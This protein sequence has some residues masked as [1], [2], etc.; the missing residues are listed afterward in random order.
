MEKGRK[1][2]QLA[3]PEFIVAGWKGG[4]GGNSLEREKEE[5]RRAAV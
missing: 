3:L 1:K 4:G 2:E 5:G